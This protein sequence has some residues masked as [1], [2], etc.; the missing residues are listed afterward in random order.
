MKRNLS[1]HQKTVKLVML[2]L[3]MS[4][5]LILSYTPLGYL[6]TAGVE[7]TFNMI[8]VAI[9]AIVLGPVGGAIIGGVFGITS[10][11]QCIGVGGLSPFG[12]ALFAINPVYTFIFCF[13]TRVLV[14]VIVGS[15]CRLT[16]KHIKRLTSVRCAIAGFLAAF[17]NT[18]LFMVTLVFLFGGDPFIKDM[19]GGRNF[20]VFACMFVGFNA[21]LEMIASTV[22]TTAV[23]VPLLKSKV[24]SK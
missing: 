8:P 3:L 12:A 11:L 7:I 17:I 22:I 16:E 9:A 21:V 6:K 24:L 13:F 1:T 2:G 23:G 18:A 4:I 10:F 20:I 19:I 14:G 5:M 15:V